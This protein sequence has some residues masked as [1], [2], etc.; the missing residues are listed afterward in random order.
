MTTAPKVCPV[1]SLAGALD[2][3]TDGRWICQSCKYEA[4]Q[5]GERIETV[6]VYR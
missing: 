6:R 2:E 3:L 5:R 4:R 1:C